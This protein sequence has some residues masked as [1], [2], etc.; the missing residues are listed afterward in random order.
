MT[1]SGGV[2]GHA[3]IKFQGP[4]ASMSFLSNFTQM[5]ETTDNKIQGNCLLSV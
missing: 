4:G 1:N 5:N 2:V 3:L